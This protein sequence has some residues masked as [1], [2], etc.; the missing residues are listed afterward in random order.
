MFDIPANYCLRIL[1]SPV[2]YVV[3]L[4]AMLV[5]YGLW[6]MKRWVWYTLVLVNILLVYENAIW[7]ND[8]GENHHKLLAF[9]TSSVF[10]ALI[11]Y[12]V[13]SEIRV[14][15]FFPKIR[16]WESD[17]R[18]RLSVPVALKRNDGVLINGDILD[19]SMSGCF[20]KLRSDISRDEEVSLDFLVFG[21]GIKCNGVVVWCTNSTVTHPRGIGVKFLAMERVDRRRLRLINRRLKKMAAFYRRSRYLLNQEEFLKKMAEIETTPKKEKIRIG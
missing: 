11:T 21:Y 6:E 7:V 5:G 2:Y 3:S 17:P 13:S 4:L 18:Y 9:L 1:L 8:Y 10:I 14:P 15:Y 12:W 16:W 19:L 20:I